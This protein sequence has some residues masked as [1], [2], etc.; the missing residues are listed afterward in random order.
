MKTATAQVQAPLKNIESKK[1]TNNITYEQ[2][3]LKYNV[4][5]WLYFPMQYLLIRW[6]VLG[7]ALTPSITDIYNGFNVQQIINIITDFAAH[8]TGIFNAEHVFFIAFNILPYGLRLAW[9][10]IPFAAFIYAFYT[11]IV[12]ICTQISIVKHVISIKID[13][14]VRIYTGTR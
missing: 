13:T 10:L 4:I 1:E 12:F 2:A 11:L 3:T 8:L 7:L 6:L 5:A 9:Q 14:Y